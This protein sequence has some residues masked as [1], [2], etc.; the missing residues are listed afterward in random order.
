MKQNPISKSYDI[1]IGHNAQAYGTHITVIGNNSGAE[2]K[3]NDVIIGDFISKPI[4]SKD[5][6]LIMD[7]FCVG[8]TLFGK[9][10]PIFDFLK[11]N[12]LLSIKTFF[13]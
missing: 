11:E 1:A 7:R 9:P 6:I 13:E 3:D 10:N 2:A 8:K 5:T 4:E 12:L